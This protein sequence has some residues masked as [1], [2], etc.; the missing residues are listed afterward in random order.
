[1]SESESAEEML[2]CELHGQEK[3]IT[4][5]DDSTRD[6]HCMDVKIQ[7]SKHDHMAL[8]TLRLITL[9]NKGI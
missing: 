8:A 4:L 5:Q 3:E 9:Y 6:L 7:L 1:M 2:S